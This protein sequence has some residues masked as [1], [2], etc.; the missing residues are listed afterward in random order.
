MDS[1]RELER[2]APAP[3]TSPNET[4]EQAAPGKLSYEARKEQSK[5]I[6]KAEKAVAEAE[7]QIEGLENDIRRLEEK[8]ATPEGASDT[9]LYNDYSNLKH[10]LSETMDKWAELTEELE[11]LN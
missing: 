11:R 5:A 3:G 8:L 6:R 7:A 9:A 4:E 1:L 2:T 10:Q